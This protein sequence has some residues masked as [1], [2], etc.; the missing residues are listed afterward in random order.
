MSM[1]T[2]KVRKNMAQID[3]YFHVKYDF[4]Y[5]RYMHHDREI[6]HGYETLF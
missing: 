6:S 5:M 2:T 1:F 4:I 3:S